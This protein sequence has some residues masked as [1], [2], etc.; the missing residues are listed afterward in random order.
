MG[1]ETEVIFVEGNSKDDTL[2][3]IKR[4]MGRRTDVE[5][6]LF[7]QDGKGKR[8]AVEPASLRRP[9]TS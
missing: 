4:Q 9:A 1:R 6:K 2:A 8:N 3:T 7:E 5:I